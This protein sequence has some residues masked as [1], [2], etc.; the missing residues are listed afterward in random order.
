[1]KL[2]DLIEYKTSN[3]SSK[4]YQPYEIKAFK[5]GREFMTYINSELIKNT[6]IKLYEEERYDKIIECFKPRIEEYD[7]MKLNA[8]L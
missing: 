8:H 4:D 1:L 3:V 2:I 7:Q 6:L 5:T